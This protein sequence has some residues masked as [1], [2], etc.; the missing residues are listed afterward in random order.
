MKV[1]GCGNLERGDDAAGILVARRLR[2]WGIDARAATSLFDVW[3]P[4]DDVVLVDAM[5]SGRETGAVAVWEGVEFP[6]LR[7]FRASTH[8]LGIAEMIWL[9]RALDRMPIRL[10][11]YGIEGR[12]FGV[13]SKLSP[14]VVQAV[15]AVSVRIAEEAGVER[16][17]I[18]LYGVVQGVGFR[19]FVY[20]LA[21]Q[22]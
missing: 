14:E 11:I 8:N 10:R 2:E 6:E 20:R 15:D 12:R 21:N 16:L 1:I 5:S 13:G 7:Q 3:D 19:P 18:C 22:M 9:A 4:G 17:R